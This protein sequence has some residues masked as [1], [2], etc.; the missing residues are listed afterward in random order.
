MVNPGSK[1][2]PSDTCSISQI[3]FLN[4]FDGESKVTGNLPIKGYFS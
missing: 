2:G 3:A 1:L 4:S